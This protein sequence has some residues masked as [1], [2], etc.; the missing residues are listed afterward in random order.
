MTHPFT[1]GEVL[2]AAETS[3]NIGPLFA[4]RLQ[5][6]LD[7]LPWDLAW[8]RMAQQQ[9]AKLVSGSHGEMIVGSA[10]GDVASE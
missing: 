1:I 6:F 2:R 3:G 9:R 5:R 7:S 4:H 8:E 10:I